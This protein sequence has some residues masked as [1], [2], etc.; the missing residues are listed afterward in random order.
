[1]P[2]PVTGEAELTAALI[3]MTSRPPQTD[4]LAP[5]LA[6]AIKMHANQ[7]AIALILASRATALADAAGSDPTLATVSTKVT[8]C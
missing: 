2:A 7:N 5:A 3:S 4:M 6:L 1:M 8:C